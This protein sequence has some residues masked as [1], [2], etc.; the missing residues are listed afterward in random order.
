[1]KI[2]TDF[3]ILHEWMLLYKAIIYQVFHEAATSLILIEVEA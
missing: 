2:K 1:M 3:A